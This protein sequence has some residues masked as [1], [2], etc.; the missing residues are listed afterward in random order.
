MAPVAFVYTCQCGRSEEIEVKENL[1]DYPLLH[2]CPRCVCR[3]VLR[4]ADPA[5]QYLERN[6]KSGKPP[7]VPRAE[8][9]PGT[10]GFL[11]PLCGRR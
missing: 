4:T 5:I 2:V 9:K 3:N 6:L 8:S 7:S 11:C 1:D 10:F